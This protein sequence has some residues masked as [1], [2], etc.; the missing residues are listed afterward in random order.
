[1]IA[2]CSDS[3]TSPIS[4]LN[5][6]RGSNISKFG[7][8]QLWGTPLPK[9]NNLTPITN[10]GSVDEGYIC[11]AKIWFS[12]VPISEKSRPILAPPP[13]ICVGKMCW[14]S[15]LAHWAGGKY[16]RDWICWAWNHYS[17]TYPYFYRGWVKKVRKFAHVWYSVWS[18]DI[19]CTT[20]VQDQVSKVKVKTW[21]SRLIA[22]LLL[23]FSKSRSLD[24]ISM[25][26]FAW[27]R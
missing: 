9:W 17:S 4:L 8:F 21:K 20:N 18:R 26:V 27:N 7:H 2:L 3:D 14:M 16:I 6:T 23:S 10:W 12:L 1:M 11:P 24:L 15:Q 22:K 19:R 25:S 5:F 13:E